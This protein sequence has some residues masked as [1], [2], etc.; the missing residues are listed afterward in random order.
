MSIDMLEFFSKGQIDGAARRRHPEPCPELVSR[1]GSGSLHSEILKS[2]TL[3]LNQGMVQKDPKK[4][5]C[6]EKGH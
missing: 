1:V 6:I 5:L 3:N 4:I 2:Q